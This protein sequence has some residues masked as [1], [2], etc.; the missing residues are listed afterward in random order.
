VRYWEAQVHG[1]VTL[2]DIDTVYF[3][4]RPD[5]I[6]RELLEDNNINWVVEQ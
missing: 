5:A 6:T 1:G 3:S 2:K 4:R